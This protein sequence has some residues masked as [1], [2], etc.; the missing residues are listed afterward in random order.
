MKAKLKALIDGWGLFT[1]SIVAVGGIVAIVLGLTQAYQFIRDAPAV[2]ESNSAHVVM[3]HDSIEELY[4]AMTA[5]QT[6]AEHVDEHLVRND[7]ANKARDRKLDY[8]VCLRIERK[9]ELD[10]LPPLR[11]CDAE[12]LR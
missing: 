1:K 3:H 8:L 10:S 2:V 11:D 9:R 7:S 4:G 5:Q 6:I 12:L